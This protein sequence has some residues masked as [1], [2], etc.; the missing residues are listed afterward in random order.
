MIS[1][2]PEVSAKPVAQNNLF[3]PAEKKKLLR[4]GFQKGPR[5]QYWGSLGEFPPNVSIWNSQSKRKSTHFMDIHIRI[6][7]ENASGVIQ[8]T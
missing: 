5:N 3:A 4:I 8:S 6:C 1:L 2:Q 7:D